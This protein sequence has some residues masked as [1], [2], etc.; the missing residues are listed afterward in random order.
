MRFL[1]RPGWLAF[2]VT[3]IGFSV[4]CYTLLAPWQFRRNAEREQD[5]AAISASVANPPAPLAELLVVGAP[6][7][8]VEWRRALAR[9]QYVDGA[10]AVVRLRSVA[11]RPAYEVLSALRT[12]DGRTIAVNRGYLRPSP[13]NRVPAYPAPPAGEVALTGRIRLDEADPQRRP[14]LVADGR[15]QIYAADSRQLAAITGQPVTGGY[16]SLLA[17]QPGVL[18]ELPLPDT[19][20]GPFLSYAL[21]W[22]TFGAMGLFGLAY[23][24][25]LELLQR[26]DP[27]SAPAPE[28]DPMTAR[29][30]RAGTQRSRR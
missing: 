13:D 26:R 5:N 28:P 30:G 19:D 25:R 21:Q 23:F 12:D 15:R 18:A 24:I 17:G 6:T 3:V 14:A 11:G 27:G 9:G 29:Y 1:F 8:A 2:V 10:E 7:T 22:L 20:G 4:A 16:L